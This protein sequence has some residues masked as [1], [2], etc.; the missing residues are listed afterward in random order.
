MRIALL[1]GDGY[2]SYLLC[3]RVIEGDDH[4]VAAI[5]LSTRFRRS[6]ARTVKVV[7]GKSRRW[8]R[9]RMFM[10]FK[11]WVQGIVRGRSVARAGAR[12][13]VPVA[14]TASINGTIAAGGMPACDLAIA[15]NLDQVLDSVTLAAF[16]YGVINVHA[17]RLP[18]GRGV[19]PAL[20]AFARGETSTWVTF[21]RMDEGLDSGPIY[22][23]IEIPIDGFQSA[24]PMYEQ[25]CA[26]S[27]EEL[28]AIIGGIATGVLAP[29]EQPSGRGDYHGVPDS[30][31]DSCL[32]SSG[33]RLVVFKD[34]RRILAAGDR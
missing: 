11:S 32:R 30:D 13:G 10:S 7:R 28:P 27:G 25:V 8:L 34:I 3:R 5:F 29:V 6:L 2:A 23:Q 12:R 18:D 22:R 15:I 14:Y 20:W 17:S 26:I 21:Y 33:R 1:V 9:Y 19:S 24:V 4:P 31:F 16:P